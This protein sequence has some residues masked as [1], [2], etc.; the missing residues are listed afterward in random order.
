[1]VSMAL[2]CEAI[3]IKNY[4][5][6]PLVLLFLLFFVVTNFPFQNFPFLFSLLFDFKKEI[7]VAA[8]TY[9]WDLNPDLSIF[10]YFNHIALCTILSQNSKIK[11]NLLLLALVIFG[12]KSLNQCKKFPESI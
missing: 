2:N 3:C 11:Q 1:M 5:A 7:L 6:F 9:F 10:N 8:R 4:F 12:R